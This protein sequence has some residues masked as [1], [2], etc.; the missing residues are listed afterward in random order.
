MSRVH[1]RRLGLVLLASA[2]IALPWIAACSSETEIESSGDTGA[3]TAGST[4]SGSSAAPPA[5]RT[6]VVD[7]EAVAEIMS[8]KVVFAAPLL[9]S[10]SM[11]DYATIATNAEELRKLSMSTAFAVSDTVA[12]RALSESFRRDVTALANAAKALDHAG[13]EAA[14]LR[15]AASCFSCH[16][17]VR[18]E[19]ETGNLPGRLTMR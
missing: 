5:I 7:R 4:P 17:H 6:G 3:R 14:Y 16:N 8:M 15:V 2:A 11:R 12:Y 19:R 18:E 10:I 13:T 1:T 9:Q